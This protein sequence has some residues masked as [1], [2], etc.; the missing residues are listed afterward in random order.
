[1]CNCILGER[2][3]EELQKIKLLE[4]QSYRNKDWDNYNK[5]NSQKWEHLKNKECSNGRIENK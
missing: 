3:C 2:D 4:N 5:F 1:M